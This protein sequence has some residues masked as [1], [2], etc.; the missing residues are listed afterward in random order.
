MTGT[1]LAQESGTIH[2][3]PRIIPGPVSGF[4]KT[5]FARLARLRLPEMVIDLDGELLLVSGR[6]NRLSPPDP[7]IR[8]LAGCVLPSLGRTPDP[9]DRITLPGL[10]ELHCRL[11]IRDPSA[12]NPFTIRRTLIFQPL[13]HRGI[14]IHDAS[15]EILQ[16]RPATQSAFYCT[17]I[18]FR[19]RFT[20][21]AIIPIR[22]I[23][24]GTLNLHPLGGEATCRPR[25]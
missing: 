11:L 3:R 10:P 16:T 8:F 4:A 21:D 7:T 2:I 14:R 13:H 17:R 5:F 19:V 9:I 24:S 18:V 15:A 20:H 6:T 12:G 25:H 23:L 22:G 1:I